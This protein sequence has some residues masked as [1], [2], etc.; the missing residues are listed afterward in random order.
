MRDDILKFIKRELIGPDPVKPHIQENGEEILL[1]EPPRLRYGAGILFPSPN[2]D[3]EGATYSAADSTTATEEEVIKNTEETSVESSETIV[4]NNTSSNVGDDF[5]EEIG[6]ANNF[7]PSA[8]G[9]SCFSKIPNEG[10][11]V[12]VNVGIYE[13]NDYCYKKDDGTDVHRKAYYRTSLNQPLLIPASDIPLISGTSKEFALVGKDSKKIELVLNIRNRTHGNDSDKNIHLLTFTLINK[14][15]GAR[16]NIRNEDCFFQVSF[17]VNASEK[18]FC[19]Y[20]LA[21]SKTDQDDEKSNQLLFRKKKTFAVGHGCSPSW[22]DDDSEFVNTITTEAIPSYEIKPIVPNELKSLALKMFDMSDLTEGDIT[23]NLIQLNA[24]YENWINEQEGIAN[25]E[26]TGEFLT[27]AKRH[28]SNCRA[29]L[30]RMKE[31]VDLLKSN[32]KVNRA[33]RL[34]NKAMLLQQ[35]HYGIDT[36]NWIVEKGVI[37]GLEKAIIPDLN[38]QST[39]QKNTDGSLRVGSWRPFQ[40]AFIL[41]NLHSMLD[42]K[43][44]DRKMVDLIW[45]PTGGGKTE[46]YLGL[47]AYTIFLRKLKDKT[48]SGTSVLMRYTLRLL[49]AQ[50]FQRAAALICACEKIREENKDE[51]GKDRITIGL[52]VGELTPNKRGD[53][54]KTLKKMS[55]GKEDESPF[56][57]LKCPWCGSQMG[58]IKGTKKD[59][60]KGYKTRKVGSHETVIF[61]CDNDSECDFSHEEFRLPLLVI[62]EDIYDF[63]PTLLIGTVDKFAMLTWRPEARSLFG[64]IDNERKTPPELIIQDE[65]HLISGPLGSM[66]GLYET[67]IEELCTAND[68]KPKIIASSA[69]ISRAKEQINSLYGRGVENVNIFPSQ[70]LS[71]GDSFF[72]Y[73]E[74]SS[75]NAPGRLYVGVFASAL[76]S[77]ATAQVRVLSALLQSVKSIPV[78]DEKLRDPYWTAL[79]YFNSIRELGHAATL[80]RADITEYLNSIYIRKKIT[81]TDRR[82]I[83]VDRE[84]TSRINSSQITDILEDLMK[85]YPKEKYPIDICLATNMISVGVDIPRLG[86]MTVIGQP[87]TTSEYIQATSRVGRSK[88]GP[89]LIFTI[90]NCSKPRDR[91]HFEHFQEYHSKIYSKV[92]PTSV[93]PFSPPARERA[94]HAILVGLIRF[95]SETNRELPTPFP[96]RE[97]IQKVREII[98]R[99]VSEIDKGE[100]QKTIEMV[101]RKLEQWQHNLPIIYGSFAQTDNLPLMYPA[102]TNP[103]EQTKLRAWS[104]PTSMRNVDSTCDAIV[105]NEYINIDTL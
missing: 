3:G 1:N 19:P 26:L 40:I 95:Y 86:L 76:P 28:I 78:A 9:F 32:S 64:F 72:A 48:D 82:F 61:K 50:Q 4:D 67:M 99:R 36:R 31:G 30:K 101:E 12:Q 37:T 15:K 69:T 27:T 89:G 34:M 60:I 25:R 24:E 88:K 92:E 20:K 81:G 53:A 75:D 96:T 43:H 51:L 57:V 56:V 97:I 16:E 100:I 84:L 42:E 39:W 98:F 6:L 10:F 91:S 104:T 55:Q 54:T 38:D 45:F 62:D 17:S 21:A 44:P 7:L 71:A 90:Y 66:V 41:I 83:N 94:L 18:C 46:A 87:K 13:I 102:G 8:M 85:E 14:N 79:T 68:I 74:R 70:C 11:K 80:I 35:L 105:I 73:E 23:S 93:T 103:P 29:C 33:F 2:K 65:L 5:E 22:A 52:W 63:P 77:H 47:S 58:L 59:E 49:T